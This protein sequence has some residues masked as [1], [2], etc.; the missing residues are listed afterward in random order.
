VVAPAID[1]GQPVAGTLDYA[2][3]MT[4]ADPALEADQGWL[5][6]TAYPALPLQ[7]WLVLRPIAVSEKGFES[8][9]VGETASG[10]L[11]LKAM[12]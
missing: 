6:S 11:I 7:E 2:L 8:Q 1:R 4:P 5:R 10:M 12:E 3:E 9:V